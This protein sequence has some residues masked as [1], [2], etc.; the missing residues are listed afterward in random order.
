MGGPVQAPSL[1]RRAFGRGKCEALCASPGPEA[2]DHRESRARNPGPLRLAVVRDSK[3]RSTPNSPATASRSGRLTGSG[4]PSLPGTERSSSSARNGEGD[5]LRTIADSGWNLAWSPDGS[6][7][8]FYRIEGK[9]DYR[10]EIVV[11]D[12]L[13]ERRTTLTSRPNHPISSVARS[14]DGNWL[15]FYADE[16][17]NHI[18]FDSSAAA[19]SP[20]AGNWHSSP[21][22]P[23]RR[24][25]PPPTVRMRASGSLLPTEAGRIWSR[26]AST[27]ALRGGALRRSLNRAAEPYGTA[28]RTIRSAMMTPALPAC[29]WAVTV[30]SS[31]QTVTRSP[32]SM[33]PSAAAWPPAPR[34]T[35]A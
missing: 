22:P 8:A 30:A 5:S 14:P 35:V 17:A 9:E 3:R 24:T 16:G 10:Q 19:W 6:K 4:S 34:S 18:S 31:V 32:R 1:G 28:G 11:F 33:L 15:S 12:L 21:G 13:T 7:L 23:R 27:A 20:A 29:A 26:P 2:L 25:V